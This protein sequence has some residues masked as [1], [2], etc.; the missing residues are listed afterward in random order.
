ME[1]VKSPKNYEKEKIII[2]ILTTFIHIILLSIFIWIFKTHNLIFSRHYTLNFILTFSIFFI[3]DKIFSFPLSLYGSYFIE[4]KYQLSNQTLS[5]F[6][7][8]HLK[9]TLLS[10]VIEN[11]LLLVIFFFMKYTSFWWI[12]AF[13]FSLIVIIFFSEFASVIFIPIFYKLEKIEDTEL[14]EMLKKLCEKVNI[15]IENLYKIKFS[16]KT[17]TANAM[18]TGLGKKKKVILSDTLLEN[19]S[20][21]EIKTIIA[22][23]LGHYYYKHIHLLIILQSVLLF[24]AFFLLNFILKETSIK[25]YDVRNIFIFILFIELFFLF[26]TPIIN[27]ISRFMERVAD[28]FAIRLTNDKKSF[29]SALKKLAKQNLANEEPHPLIEFLFYSHPP[30]KKRIKYLEKLNFSKQ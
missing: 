18:F 14:I 21:S 13:L 3:V 25:I 19:Y 27:I 2:K 28:K 4:K 29:I 9:I 24:C 7:K 8:D 5:E 20:H 10:Y 16:E 12:Y 1:Q 15:K 6:L 26:F 17:K 30:I 23:E 22:H 11:F